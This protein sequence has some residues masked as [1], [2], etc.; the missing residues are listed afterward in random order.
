M[1]NWKE[2]K[3]I[4]IVAIVVG[5]LA[6]AGI[7]FSFMPKKVSLTLMSESTGQVIKMKVKIGAEFPI[8]D[9][10]TGKT[11]LYPAMGYKCSNGHEFYVLAKADKGGLSAMPPRCPVDG[12]LEVQPIEE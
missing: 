9:P 8:V 4:G 10:A 7:V 2:N 1:A 12:T 6:I 5:I 11:D 3:I